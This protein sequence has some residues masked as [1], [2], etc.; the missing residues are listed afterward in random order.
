MAL[1]EKKSEN[2][3][4]DYDRYLGRKIKLNWENEE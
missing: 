4:S 1:K 3:W 2:D